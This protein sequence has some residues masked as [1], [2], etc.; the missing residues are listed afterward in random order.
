MPGLRGHDA[1]QQLGG[2]P[3]V[4]IYSTGCKRSS[5]EGHV[6]IPVFPSIYVFQQNS[7]CSAKLMQL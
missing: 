5:D 4:G 6:P 2:S 7:A 3:Y 1:R